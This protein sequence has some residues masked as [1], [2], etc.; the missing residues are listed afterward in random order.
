MSSSSSY[1]KNK[2]TFLAISFNLGISSISTLATNY[3]FMNKFHTT[4]H[5]RSYIQTISNIPWYIKPVFGLIT[6]FLPIC[7][8][9][10][11][12]YIILMGLLQCLCLMLLKYMC[13]TVYHAVVL[14]F[15]VNVSLSFSSII[16]QAIFV[17]LSKQYSGDKGKQEL[18]ILNSL[19]TFYKYIGILIASVLKGVL[20]EMFTLENVFIIS[21]FI[22]IV[23]IIAGF[24]F[25]EKRTNISQTKDKL[26]SNLVHSVHTHNTQSKSNC[27]QIFNY[28]T[29]IR[30]LIIIVFIILLTGLPPSYEHPLFYYNDEVSQFKPNDFAIINLLSTVLSLIIIYLYKQYLY[31][32]SF[33]TT[34][35]IGRG[36]FILCM[37]AHYIVIKGYNVGYIS[38]YL[39]FVISGPIGVA[40]REFSLLPVQVLAGL[41]CPENMEGTVYAVFMSGINVGEGLG[42]VVGSVMMGKLDIKKGCFRNFGLLLEILMVLASVPI[43]VLGCIKKD[44][45][46]G[47]DKKKGKNNRNEEED[48]ELQE[49]NDE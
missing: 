25:E 39:I 24:V 42:N 34:V 46:E 28:I 1:I 45:L 44:V 37:F 31:A 22:P 41:L 8:Y 4:P 33:K 43:V 48:I 11:K 19:Y 14:F 49:K 3:L 35:T 30:I 23:V 13:Y 47:S 7:G 32:L 29:E 16:S 38:D 21:S 15:L 6:D 5:I 17:E 40:A 10:R 12:V 27:K 18:N 26:I 2:F 20:V 36:V 9:R